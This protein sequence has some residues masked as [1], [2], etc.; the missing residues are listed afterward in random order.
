L[1]RHSFIGIFSR[2][3][4]GP[5]RRGRAPHGR[6]GRAVLQAGIN[7]TSPLNP[8]APRWRRGPTAPRRGRRAPYPRR[9]N[10]PPDGHLRRAEYGLPA[11]RAVSAQPVP[12]SFSPA[13]RKSENSADGL[14]ESRAT[15]S[16]P[17]LANGPPAG[18]LNRRSGVLP[19]GR[20]ARPLLLNV[21]L[22]MWRRRHVWF[23]PLFTD[24][25]S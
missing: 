1:L 12:P 6:D 22:L 10:L 3:L 5:C 23:A 14:G 17:P 11:H 2:R 9:R 16:G 18:P 7:R 19:A 21:P 4:R 20:P 24:F 13:Y 15:R 8:S 25:Y